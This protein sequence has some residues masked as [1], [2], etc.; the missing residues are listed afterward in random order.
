MTATFTIGCDPEVMLEKNGILKSAIGL[1]K[2]TKEKP[3]PV[4]KGAIQH[5]NV[6]AEFNVDPAKSKKEFS[7]NIKAVLAD[8]VK[9]VAPYRIKVQASADFP[10]SELK[11]PK[12]RQ[13]GCDPD[14]DAWSVSMVTVPPGATAAAF[15]S[16]GGHLHVGALNDKQTF[17]L[18]PYGKLDTVRILDV[19]VG[20]PSL[21]MDK[22]PT[23]KAR[24]GLYG[25][26]G[27]H[28][29]TSYGVEYR[30]LGNYW[31]SSPKYVEAVY[32][33]T[34]CAVKILSDGSFKE[35]LKKVSADKVQDTINNSKTADAVTLFNDVIKKYIDVKTYDCVTK[36]SGLTNIPDIYKEWKL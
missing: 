1:I 34:D 15:R 6:N 9:A 24:R 11:H 25:K 19:V 2:G 22:D 28:R 20:I 17:L 14:F 12:A 23:S 36:L 32:N 5:D 29:P 27:C 31:I 33:L 10:A 16:A 26:A 7:E 4:S 30:A 13:F 3:T 35:L 8:L 18:D 21:L